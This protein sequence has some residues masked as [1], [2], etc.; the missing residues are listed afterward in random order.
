M[1]QSFREGSAGRRPASRFHEPSGLAAI[2]PDLNHA[3]SPFHQLFSVSSEVTQTH[4]YRSQNRGENRG[5]VANKNRLPVKRE[6]VSG[7]Q[8]S[9]PTHWTSAK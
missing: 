1:P 2:M 6:S 5:S 7:E 4:C 3:A 8:V 9:A